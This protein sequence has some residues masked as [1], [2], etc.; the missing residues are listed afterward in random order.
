MKL[1]TNNFRELVRDIQSNYM[2]MQK[3]RKFN[4]F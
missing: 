4:Y 1:L 3:Y 2:C